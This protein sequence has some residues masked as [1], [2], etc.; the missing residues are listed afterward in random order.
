M[1]WL[2]RPK[3]IFGFL[4]N[5]FFVVFTIFYAL[6]GGGAHARR[7]SDAVR[8][9]PAAPG[10]IY[11]PLPPDPSRASS[12][13]VAGRLHVSLNR[14][15]TLIKRPG[16]TLSLSP[17]FDALLRSPGEPRYV[18]FRFTRFANGQ[19]CPGDCPLSFKADGRLYWPDGAA[20]GVLR[21]PRMNW[22][23]QSVP[24]SSEKLPDGQVLE[25]MAADTLSTEMPYDV[26]AEIITSNEV[27][28]TLGADSVKLTL[29][30]LEALRDMH[31]Q[32]MTPPPPQ[33]VITK[34][35]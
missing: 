12:V 2:L 25:T 33:P 11:A 30:Q 29:E 35:Y 26:F 4:V 5:Y 14:D 23:R 28:L 15:L 17:S 21:A 9:G 3:V 1:N 19:N 20:G 27:V 18:T 8:L 16:F 10:V 6:V 31:R 24:R 13:N 34:S 7:Q 32:L 22:S